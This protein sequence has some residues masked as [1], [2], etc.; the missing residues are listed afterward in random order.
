[1]RTR[2]Q[3]SRRRAYA[4]GWIAILGLLVGCQPASDLSGVWAVDKDRS[5]NLEPWRNIQLHISLGEGEVAIGRL[6]NPGHR[7]T[8]RDSISFP[9]DDTQVEIPMDGSAKWLEQPHLGVFIDGETPQQVRASWETPNR[10]LNVQHLVTVQTSQGAA[11]VEILRN[12]SLSSDGS[13]LTVVETRS[14][15]PT[16][17]TY[18]YTRP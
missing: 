12:Y 16:P 13:E 18:V 1:M 15:R 11:T 7:D 2:R 8:R 17:L 5:S 3:I 6:F 9:V 4:S 10:V 14:S